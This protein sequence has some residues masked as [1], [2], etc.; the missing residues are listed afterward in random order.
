MFPNAGAGAE[1]GRRV[2]A[3][4][5]DLTFFL[6]HPAA[7]MEIT[8]IQIK[9][10]SIRCDNILTSRF[11][12]TA[13]SPMQPWQQVYDPLG[14]VWLSTISAALPVCL[15]FY[16]LAIRRTAAHRAAIYASLLCIALAA[17]EFHMSVAKLAGAERSCKV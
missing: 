3:T 1:G 8:V 6:P 12:F 17:F 7:N 16:L 10:R 13:N 4:G 15:L 9:A 2:T 11:G 5:A 14:N